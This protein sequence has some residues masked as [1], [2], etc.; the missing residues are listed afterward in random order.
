[1][2]ESHLSLGLGSIELLLDS[3]LLGLDLL[4]SFSLELGSDLFDLSVVVLE[5]SQLVIKL[6]VSLLLSITVV[7]LD[8]D[9]DLLGVGLFKGGSSLVGSVSLVG[10]VLRLELFSSLLLSLLQFLLDLLHGDGRVF[11]GVFKSLLDLWLFIDVLVNDVN[12]E[13]DGIVGVLF[14]FKEVH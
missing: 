1:M 2:L 5:F 4:L 11:I 10:E 6:D 13:G 8:L 9:L 12:F 3:F 14:F 7:S